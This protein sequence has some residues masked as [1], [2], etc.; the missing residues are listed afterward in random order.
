MRKTL[1]AVGLLVC[2]T[3]AGAQS[4]PASL[5][6]ADAV[7][8]ARDNN[9][10][11]RQTLSTRTAS[12]W[13]ARS[14]WANLFIPTATA[15]GSIAYTGPG[16]QNFL[17][18]SF[19]QPVSTSSSQYNVGLNWQLNGQILA[20]PGLQHAN[21]DAV[22]ADIVGARA[23]LVNNV[24]QQYLTALQARD[25]A[26]VADQQLQSTD[27]ALKLAQAKYAVGSGTLL[28][29]RNAQVAHGQAEVAL[30]QAQTSVQTE[31]LRLFEQMGVTAPV[32]IKTVQLSDTFPVSEPKF[33]LDELLATAQAQNPQLQ[34]LESRASAM[35]WSV[36]AATASYGPSLNVS[37]GWS[38]FTQRFNDINPIITNDQFAANANWQACNDNNVIRANAGLST[39]DCSGLLFGSS[40]KQ[41]IIDQNNQYPFNFTR[42]PFSA[43][44]TI[45]IPLWSNFQQPIAVSQAKSNQEQADQAARAQSLAL[46]TLVQNGYLTLQTAYQTI[47]IQD[48]NRTAA[49]EGLKLA[50]DRYR[51][52]SGTFLDV[53][54]A[55]VAATK[56]EADYVSAIYN[57]HKARAALEAAVGRPLH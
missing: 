49:E 27:Q 15:S 32:D 13:N 36:R 48:T 39:E 38:G 31:K 19:S 51:V 6:L 44:L 2:P 4:T 54:N 7:A 34:A 8:I 29:V 17:S 28:D 1:L 26:T 30:L 9:P 33:G 25:N 37:A 50:T 45:S 56:A 10:A 14:A 12:L 20:G 57:Y 22:D 42:Q 18:T 5:S 21:A 41:A 52:G 35:K 3:F 40:Q 53:V 55:Q 16:S 11:Y 43:R 24:T 23:T 46:R 47:A